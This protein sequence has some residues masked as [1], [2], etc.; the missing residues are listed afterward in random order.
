L[1]FKQRLFGGRKIFSF[2]P[3]YSLSKPFKDFSAFFHTS[4]LYEKLNKLS[5]HVYN[6][7][8][9]D[10]HIQ[11]KRQQDSTSRLVAQKNA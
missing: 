11:K 9:F 5:S 1:Q 6:F 8:F 4:K 7:N 10:L 3:H 2:Q